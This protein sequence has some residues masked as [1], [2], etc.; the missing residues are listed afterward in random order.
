LTIPIL[1]PTIIGLGFDPIWFGV[2][3]VRVAEIGLITPPI[4]LNSFVIAGVT[5][6]P[7][8]TVFRGIVPFFIADIL[9]VTLL[10]AVPGV[11]LFLPRLMI[12]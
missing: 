9:H 8:G 6:M 1:Y 11:S 3:F 7:V 12:Q 4:G 5:E 2:I 10:V